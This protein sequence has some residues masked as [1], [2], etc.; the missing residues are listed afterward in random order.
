MEKFIIP[1]IK[2]RGKTGKAKTG[3]ERFLVVS[4]NPSLPD[5]WSQFNHVIKKIKEIHKRDFPD[6]E[7][8]PPFAQ[9]L[10]ATISESHFTE[11]DFSQLGFDFTVVWVNLSAFRG[12]DYNYLQK[13]R[14]PE[15]DVYV[16]IRGQETT[17]FE[18]EYG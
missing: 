18:L 3:K 10:L 15:T 1:L 16:S 8:V 6:S 12:R 13:V 7:T 14:V 2:G 9:Q 4:D 17:P 5:A 11:T